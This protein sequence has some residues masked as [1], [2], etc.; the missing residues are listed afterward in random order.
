[1]KRLAD[2]VFPD[3]VALEPDAVGAELPSFE[4]PAPR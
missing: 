1:M 3:G 2:R 4:S